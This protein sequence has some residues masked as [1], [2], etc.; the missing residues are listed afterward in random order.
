[1]RTAVPGFSAEETKALS[2]AQDSGEQVEVLSQRTEASQVFANPSGT[3][4]EDRFATAQWARKGNK[5]VDIDTDLVKN[6]D[7][8]LSPKATGVGLEFSSGGGGP[9]ATITRDGRS[10]SLTWPT[11]LP[12]AE[13]DGDTVTYPDVLPDVDLKLR[14]GA[15]GFGQLLV[16]KTAEAAANP[17]LKDI[18]YKM[19]TNGVD[20]SADDAGNLSAKNPAGQELFTAPTPRMWDSTTNQIAARLAAADAPAA[21]GTAGEFEPAPGAQQAQMPVDVTDDALKLTP[22][23]E[24]LTGSDTHY[25]VY[26]DPYVS[27]SRYSWTIAY[28]KTPGTS[29]FNGAGWDGKTT[30]TARVGY[31]NVTNG[32]ARSYFR[33]NTTNLWSTNKQVVKSTFRI[34]NTWSWSCTSKPVEMW[35]TATIGSSTTWNNRPDRREEMDT[36]ND[37]K[38]WSGDCPA[39][40]LAFDVTKGAKDAASSKWNTISLEMAASNESD[41]YGWKKFDAKSAVMSTEYNTVPSDPSSLDT[42]PSTKNSAGCGDVAP[43]GLIGNTDI[44]LTAKISDKDGGNLTARFHLWATGHHDDGPGVFFNKT[45]SVTSGTVAR[46][47]VPKDTLSPYISTASGNFSWKAQADDGKATS[48]WT[49]TLGAAGCRFVFDPNRPST[50]PA[51]NSSQFPDGSNGWPVVTGSVRT[52]GTFTLASGGVSDVTKYE[53]WT[54]TDPTVRTASPTSAGG[55]VA[56]KF[57][58][59]A[60]GTND[61]YARSLDKAGNRSDTADYLFY[62]NGLKQKDKPGDI[63]GDGNADLWATDAEGTLHRVYGAGDGT[64]KDAATPASNSTWNDTQITHRGDW[65]G[66]GYEDLIALRHDADTDTDRLWLHPNNGFGFACTDCEG[67]GTSSDRQ[68]L[69]VYDPANNHWENGAK[70]ILAVGDVDGPL[71]LDNDG[72]TDTESYPDLIVNDGKFIWLYYGSNDNRLDSGT[73]P[74]LLAG[75]DDPIS[76]GVSTVNEVTLAA[77]GDWNGDGQPDLVARYD[78]ADTGGLYV[79][80][81]KENDAGYDISVT[82]RTA[83]GNNFSTTTVPLFT[84]APDADNN[85]KLDLWATTPSSGRLRLFHD[86]TATGMGPTI[87]ASEEFTGYKA[88]S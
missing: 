42:V 27:G 71:D 77:P 62:A 22:D 24:L 56:V 45:V 80:H 46:I 52:E 54:D 40:N 67:T 74:V 84:A 20:V 11:S 21:D 85:G 1:M 36:V 19:S 12:A 31:E 65:T 51:I 64:V 44:Y 73:A 10:I 55:S 59:T 49:P 15:S 63:N 4:T 8:T 33:M 5:L 60:S 53:Y 37:S 13:V 81:G 48:D 32:L 9:L 25:P 39:G 38:G 26:I 50:P 41:V 69:T 29:Y 68:E 78:R 76:D 28:K 86:M 75:P 17:E 57:T 3:F 14:A 6:A 47:K 35:R 70:Q 7:G 58:P 2:E 82:D 83:I 87:V 66:D 61:L 72:V 88:I 18:T 34:K 23:S 43:Y 79:F 16:V 30:T